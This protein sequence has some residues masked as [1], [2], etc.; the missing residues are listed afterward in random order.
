[1]GFRKC[2]V[3]PRP[4]QWPFVDTVK[5]IQSDYVDPISGGKWAQEW[6]DMIWG[7]VNFDN[8]LY[9]YV[10]RYVIIQNGGKE[11]VAWIHR[12]P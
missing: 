1:M 6:R 7:D 12:D 10:E 2:K 11:Q 3:V 5:I 4:G 9:G 8:F